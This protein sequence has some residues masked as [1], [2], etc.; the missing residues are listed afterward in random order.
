MPSLILELQQEA[1]NSSVPVSE[2]L[3]KALIVASKL[4]LDE[5]MEWIDHEMNG[6]EKGD[7]T[8]E[9]RKVE[10]EFKTYDKYLGWTDVDFEIPEMANILTTRYIGSSV[11]GLEALISS[12]PQN[13]VTAI[14]FDPEQEIEL[15][16][17]M[18]TT[19]KPYVRINDGDIRS[20]I[21][22]I[23]NIILKWALD[24][25]KDGIL[26]E[27]Y[28]FSPSD[29]EL[30]S[31]HVLN[32]ETYIG[33]SVSQVQFGTLSSSQNLNIS[34]TDL[35]EVA[36]VIHEVQE[37]I[38]KIGLDEEKLL[39]VQA[40]LS[41][42]KAQLNSPK[43]RIPLIASCLQSVKNIAESA[44]GSAVVALIIEKLDSIIGKLM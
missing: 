7:E 14:T 18:G 13:M 16:K 34:T 10:G 1:V 15:Q 3:R 38:P 33:Q 4:E 41:T 35:G 37:S 29:K 22:K 17:N 11:S 12:R 26:G 9:Y 19:S 21:N 2:L 36:V 23:R 28:S 39:E 6:Y 40:E 43:P 24:L 44:A 31:P 30:L 32:I 20:I 42:I 8:P 27:G 25:E 5:M